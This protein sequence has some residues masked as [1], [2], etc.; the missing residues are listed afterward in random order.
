MDGIEI[1]AT[2]HQGVTC[3]AVGNDIRYDP[4]NGGVAVWLGPGTKNC[5]VV[6]KGAVKDQGTG[7]KVI[8]VR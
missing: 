6:T 7:N 8:T 2:F 1:T 4:A 5:L 3:A